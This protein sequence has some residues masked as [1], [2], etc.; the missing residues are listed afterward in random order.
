MPLNFY[1][2]V[3]MTGFIHKWIILWWEINHLTSLNKSLYVVLHGQYLMF[4]FSI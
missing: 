2:D 4:F 3:G 1:S